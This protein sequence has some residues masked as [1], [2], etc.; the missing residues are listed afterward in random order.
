MRIIQLVQ[1]PQARGAEIFTTWLCE[2]LK[3]LGHQVLLVSLFEGNFELPFSGKLIRLNRKKE[4]R[5]CD[6]TGWKKFNE[7]V[8]DFKPDLVQANGGDTLKFAVFSRKLFLGSY[9]LVFNNGGLVSTYLTSLGHRVFN[10]FLF[11]NTDAFVSVSN[12]TKQDLDQFLEANKKH[13]MIPIGIQIPFFDHLASMSPFP[14]IV[15]ISGFTHEKNHQG[16]LRIFRCFQEKHPTSQLWFI[17]DGPE[18]ATI[19]A[20]VEKLGFNS[21]IKFLGSLSQP[22]NWIPDNAILILPSISE[23]L[24]AVLLEAFFARIPVVAYGIGGI[25]EVLV[26]RKNGF[27]VNPKDEDQFYESLEQC[28]HMD[29]VTK[30]SLL[31]RAQKTVEENY[32]IAQVAKKYLDFYSELCG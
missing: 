20:E 22:F 15:Q 16:T 24:P 14:V 11:R 28:L 4:N 17:G 2:E 23:G 12:Y 18:K 3:D 10:R 7:I 30:K 21:Q 1:K 5:F 13:K 29:E 26:D 25:P 6:Y 8:Q 31:D 27:L 32:T 9:R 19:E